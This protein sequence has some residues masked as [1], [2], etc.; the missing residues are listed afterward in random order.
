[1]YNAGYGC[2]ILYILKMH[3]IQKVFIYYILNNTDVLYDRFVQMYRILD[4]IDI[5]CSR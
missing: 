2:M 4:D 5:S 1:M 3:C